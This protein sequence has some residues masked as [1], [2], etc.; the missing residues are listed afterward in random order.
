MASHELRPRCMTDTASLQNTVIRELLLDLRPSRDYPTVEY[1]V[2]A[3]GTR[4]TL[5]GPY[6]G[7]WL[8]THISGAARAEIESGVKDLELEVRMAGTAVVVHYIV[9][10]ER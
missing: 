10:D 8:Q 3:D 4:L 9:T 6:E 7:I 5:R 2:A 1:T